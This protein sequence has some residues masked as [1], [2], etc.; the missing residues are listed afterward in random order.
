V[1]TWHDQVDWVSWWTELWRDWWCHQPPTISQCSWTWSCCR[2]GQ[3]WSAVKI[4][5]CI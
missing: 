4:K 1:D 5:L 2:W 3:G